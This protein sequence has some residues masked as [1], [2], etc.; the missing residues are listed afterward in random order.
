MSCSFSLFSIAFIL[1]GGAQGFLCW[2]A[3]IPPSTRFPNLTIGNIIICTVFL[4]SHTT[5]TMAVYLLLLS[6]RYLEYSPDSTGGST[7][8]VFTGAPR[9]SSV[10]AFVVMS[11]AYIM[12]YVVVLLIYWG[13]GWEGLMNV[14][15]HHHRKKYI[16]HVLPL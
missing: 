16:T 7:N 5:I 8:I 10:V 12:P 3:V 6:V 9:W 11:S 2:L 4:V 13:N 1:T 14:F 15:V